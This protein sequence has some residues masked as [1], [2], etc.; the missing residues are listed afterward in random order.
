[1]TGLYFYVSGMFI[2]V[3]TVAL[4]GLFLVIG[5]AKVLIAPDSERGKTAISLSILTLAVLLD[6]IA[7]SVVLLVP[8]DIKYPVWL[9]FLIA[10]F[11]SVII[12]TILVRRESGPEKGIVK[13]GSIALCVVNVLGFIGLILR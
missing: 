4:G 6:I 8:N 3:L 9:V 2:S 1:V 5:W 10:S 11:T 7:L 12:S 13:V